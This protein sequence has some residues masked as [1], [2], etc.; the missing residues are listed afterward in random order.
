MEKLIV[1]HS[2]H[3]GANNVG[4]GALVAAVDKMVKQ[5][6]TKH[7]SNMEKMEQHFASIEANRRAPTTVK[8]DHW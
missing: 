2:N 3:S 7:P 4:D 5:Q 1:S 6:G 8:R